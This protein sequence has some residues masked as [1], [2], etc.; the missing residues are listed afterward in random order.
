LTSK[1]RNEKKLALRLKKG[2]FQAVFVALHG[3]YGED[4]RLQALLDRLRIPYTGSG[5]LACGLAMHKGCSKLVFEAKGIPTA[6]WQALHRSTE[7]SK[8]LQEIKLPLPLVVKPAEAGSALGVTIVRKKNQLGKAIARAFKYGPWV[9][10]EK[11][12]RGMEA[13]V[14]VLDGKALPLVEIV[15][16]N[17]FYDYE[18][19]YTPGKSDHIIPARVPAAQA[20]QAKKSAVL[21]GKALGCGGY[22]RVDLMIPKK[23]KPQVLE[24][25]TAPGMTSTSLFPDA[26]RAAG[27]P[28]PALLK[29]LAWQALSKRAQG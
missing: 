20:A 16:K 2:R 28:F 11:F 12:I 8:W 14:A 21:A 15:P 29:R 1:D 5:A 9:L 17:D 4:G 3:G 22:Y 13:T 26:A 6:P 19:R 7:K 24:V 18:A 25:N 27:I 23:G 10:V